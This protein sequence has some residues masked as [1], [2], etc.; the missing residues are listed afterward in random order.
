MAVSEEIQRQVLEEAYSATPNYDIDYND[1]RFGRVESDK[2]QALTELE[3]TYGGMINSSDQFFQNQSAALQNQA[4]QQ[5]QIQQEQTN[6]TIEKIEQQKE[7]AQKDYL[8]EQSAS[9]VDWQKQSNQYGTE[10]EKMASSGLLGTGYSESSQVSMYNTY[11]NRVATAREVLA[12]AKLNY[13][14][15]IKEAMLQNSAALA[16]IYANLYVE[17]ARLAL[18]GFQYKNQLVLDLANKKTELNNTYYNRY[19]DVLQQINTENAMAEDI[20]QYNATMAEDIRQFN[21][22][23]AEEIRQ[24]NETQAWKTEQAELDRQ[25]QAELTKLDQKFKADQNALDRKHDKEMLAAETKAEKEKLEIQYQNN[26]KILEQELANEKALLKYKNDLAKQQIG[27]VSGGSSGG[28]A[29]SKYAGSVPK[30]PAYKQLT[31]NQSSG[32]TGST[33]E[34]ARAYVKSK[35]VPSGNISLYDRNEWSRRKTSYSM[36]G[37]GGFEVKNFSSYEEYLRYYVNFLIDKYGK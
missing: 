31:T 27:T 37:F 2:N 33:Y 22:S 20:R 28:N 6:F 23:M 26:K 11:Q 34:E 14:N 35:G 17:Q 18:E 5:A 7:Q 36:N 21:E 4:N 12:Q 3:Q 25:F 29:L 15:N 8:K 16:E 10:A 19:Q 13:D 32:F 30:T 24:Y 9:Y 1:P